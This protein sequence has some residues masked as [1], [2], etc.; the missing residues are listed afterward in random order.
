M[1]ATIASAASATPMSAA[2][3]PD[4]VRAWRRAV[5]RICCSWARGSGRGVRLIERL[6]ERPGRRARA[7]RPAATSARAARAGAS[8]VSHSGLRRVPVGVVVA[9]VVGQ[10]FAGIV[11]QHAHQIV[12]GLALHPDAELRGLTNGL[13]GLDDV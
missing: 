11:Q 12:L 8:G 5:S 1:N 4:M 7:A 3:I 6:S 2:P 10:D 13:A 9:V